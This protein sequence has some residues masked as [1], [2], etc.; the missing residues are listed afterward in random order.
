MGFRYRKSINF[1]PVRINLSKSGIGWSV[2][3]KGARFTKKAN[4]GYRST[5]GVPG[6]GVSY[7]KDY[8]A[9]KKQGDKLSN[10]KTAAS[11]NH[12]GS[13]NSTIHTENYDPIQQGQQGGMKYCTSCGAKLLSEAVMCPHCGAMQYQPRRTPKKKPSAINGFLL[14]ACVLASLD[15]LGLWMMLMESTQPTDFWWGYGPFVFVGIMAVAVAALWTAFLTK[16]RAG[17][18][19]GAV[20]LCLSPIGYPLFASY[21]VLP[22]VFAWIGFAKSKKPE[23]K[24]TQNPAQSDPWDAAK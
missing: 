5:L 23:D 24:K 14:A 19:F 2:G 6:T 11:L 7:V 21:M 15:I 10:Q 22:A 1:G 13:M 20:V 3:G 9:Q 18:L 16:S 4:G 12:D 17:A 8:P